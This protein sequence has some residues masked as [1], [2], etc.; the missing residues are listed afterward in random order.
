MINNRLES[1]EDFASLAAKYS[2]DLDTARSGGELGAIPESQVKGPNTDPTTRDAVAKLKPSQVTDVI[3]IVN[4]ATQKVL[5]YRVVKLLF[6]EAAGQRDLSD[7]SVQQ[8]ILN[9]LRTH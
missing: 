8:L 3:P 5:G 7:P 4:P 9:K 6:K 2:E 1:G